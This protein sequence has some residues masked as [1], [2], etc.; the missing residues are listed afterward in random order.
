MLCDKKMD[1]IWS[2]SDQVY[3]PK[4]ET[5]EDVRSYIRALT[6]LIYDYKMIGVIYDVYAE[7]VVY[8]KQSGIRLHSP[9]EIACQVTDL[10]AAF[11][12]LRAQV[13]HIIVSPQGPDFFKVFRRMRLQGTCTGFS[14]YGPATHKSLGDRCLNLTMMHLKQIDGQWKIVFEVNSDSENLIRRTLTA[15]EKEGQA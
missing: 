6:A 11:P 5:A 2:L 14:Q 1:E 9:D 10:T 4:L 3:H 12:D 7:D 8:H 15:D 13:D